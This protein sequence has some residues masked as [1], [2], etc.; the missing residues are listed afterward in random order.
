MTKLY[1]KPEIAFEKVAVVSLPENI[2]QWH[3]AILQHVI[4]NHEYLAQYLAPGVE[5]ENESLDE[6]RGTAYGK[7]YAGRGD[8]MAWIPV[9]VSDFALQPVDIFFVGDDGYVLTET[10]FDTYVPES[11]DIGTGTISPRVLDRRVSNLNKLSSLASADEARIQRYTSALQDENIAFAM[12]R[13]GTSEKIA[14][15]IKGYVKHGSEKEA[16]LFGTARVY[17]FLPSGIKLAT[18]YRWGEKVNVRQKKSSQAVEK[19]AS[20]VACEWESVGGVLPSSSYIVKEAAWEPVK[21]PGLFKVKL[22]DGEHA[23]MFRSPVSILEANGD[24]K[25]SENFVNVAFG[26]PLDG[27]KHV[28]GDVHYGEKSTAK[29][30]FADSIIDITEAKKDQTGV[31][32]IPTAEGAA[33]LGRV[34]ILD[35]KSLPSRRSKISIKC[36]INGMKNYH[37]LVNNVLTSPVPVAEDDP[38]FVKGARN[39]EI[40][41]GWEFAPLTGDVSLSTTMGPAKLAGATVKLMPDGGSYYRFEKT[42]SDGA[43]RVDTE[44]EVHAS[45][46]LYSLGFTGD[47]V[48]L[49][50]LAHDNG[51]VIISGLRDKPVM[52]KL[53]SEKPNYD[54][55]QIERIVRKSKISQGE[56]IKL[57]SAL[58]SEIE[59]DSDDSVDAVLD[60]GLVDDENIQFFVDSI[61]DFEEVQESLVK[62]LLKAR[63]GM[64][65]VDPVTIKKAVTYLDATIKDLKELR[66][67]A[68]RN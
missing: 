64:Q 61:P 28:S 40:P 58:M 8:Q 20:G 65:E 4:T 5:W 23:Q 67:S 34:T 3:D 52:G 46:R 29:H 11:N 36:T 15:K 66:R 60:L 53:A 18:D 41:G 12:R 50:K 38:L 14:E 22:E 43:H 63:L 17:D 51:E 35:V 24:V 2:A 56:T 13:N 62:L 7:L 25:E 48:D 21:G 10:N 68:I 33:V 59:D 39:Y 45:A 32:V 27:M 6:E 37:F 49:F 30:S 19:I 42:A 9:V 26:G 47:V 55:L 44:N 16:E 31:L 1:K 54:L 57:A